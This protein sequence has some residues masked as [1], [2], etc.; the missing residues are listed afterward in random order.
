MIQKSVSQLKS[1]DFHRQLICGCLY[2]QPGRHPLSGNMYLNLQNHGLVEC[3]NDSDS[4]KYIP[5][6]LD[7]LADFLSRD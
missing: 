3:Q 4:G 5:G 6:N 2:E 7:V 1:V